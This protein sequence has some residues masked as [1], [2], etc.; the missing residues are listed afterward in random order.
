[1]SNGME[2]ILARSISYRSSQISKFI[3][4]IAALLL[5]SYT[6]AM[7]S[8]QLEFRNTLMPQPAELRTS[9]GAL[10]ISTSLTVSLNGST[11][12]L[13]KDAAL[14]LLAR[15]ES[16]TGVQLSHDFLPAG[17]AQLEISVKDSTADRPKLGVDES[18][19]L[20]VQDAKIALHAAT[21][22]GAM[23][24]LETLLQLVQPNG[25]GFAIPRVHIADA[26][27]FHWRGLLVDA[28]RH[29][30]SVPVILRTLDGM[31]AVKMNV[32][33]WHLTED[34][35][36]R[37]ESRTY[38]LLTQLGSDGLFYTQQQIRDIV[39]Y[40]AARGIRVV[41]EFDMPGHSTSWMVGYPNLGSKPGP[42]Q[43]ARVPGILDAAM[44][45]TRES[46]YTFLDAFFAEMA[47]LFPDEYFHIGG[48][49]SN[50]KDWNS[51]P[52]IVAFMQQHG[53]KSTADLQT[54]FNSRI[55]PL[56]TKHG[57][58]MVGWDEILHADL[59][60]N[61]V[62]QSWRGTKSLIDAAHQGHRGVLSQPYYLD[63]MASAA[64]MYAADP[65]PADSG[66]SPAEAKLVLGGEV[67]MWA[68]QVNSLTID[69]R[70]WPRTAAVAERF[71][72]PATITDTSDMYRRLAASSLR[73]EALGLTHV[74]TP[75]VGMRQLAGS[76]AGGQQ[77]SVLASVLQPVTF[78]ERYKEQRTSPLTPIGLFVDFTRPDPPAGHQLQTLV[79]AYLHETDPTARAA[80]KRQLEQIFHSWI[81]AAPALT[82]LA[83]TRP[84]VRQMSVRIEQLPRLGSLGLEALGYIESQQKPPTTW[85]ATQ[86]SLLAT[87]AKHVE[88]TD[89][90]VLSPLSDLLDRAT[91]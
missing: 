26:P 57:K 90:V 48:D 73:L 2:N 18:Y 40:A 77:L 43:I 4:Y 22:F 27:R 55:Q 71:W 23:H 44:D 85:T 86:R 78:G 62:I 69:S 35:G 36:F 37:I 16:Q 83:T 25:D 8:Q 82:E 29:F 46:T 67:C 50:G 54:Y 11:N 65:V 19:A 1:M 51:N 64:T 31:A 66:L 70:I 89:F 61:V 38:P 49:E 53:M 58:Q 68:E 24:G 3:L 9:P 88:L 28:G 87:S 42:Y 34:Q 21:I 47:T 56:L 84:L 17:T 12:P 41:P 52:A 76:E 45:P 32:L 14:R 7:R 81:D 60:P 72:S 63:H 74:S 10:P 13:L 39:H 80:D 91:R 15:L 30:I 33:H 79:A 5:V 6:Q 59:S 20:D 75:Q